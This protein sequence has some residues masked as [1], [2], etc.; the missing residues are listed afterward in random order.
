MILRAPM[1]RALLAAA[2][3]AHILTVAPAAVADPTEG[4]KRDALERLANSHDPA[5][6][7]TI[8]RLYVKQAGLKA[9]REL[10][11]ERGRAQGL[12]P[13]WD[14]HAPQ[15]RAAEL[16]LTELVDAAIHRDVDD[17]AWFRAAW[18]EESGKVLSA[19]EA[20]E[21]ATH[22]ASQ[23][24]RIQRGVIEMLIVGETLLANYTFTD[25]I[26]YDV[27]GSERELTELQELWWRNQ[28]FTVREV[29]HYP[30]TTRFA[31]TDPGVKYCKMLAIQGIDAVNRHLDAVVAQ[32]R[33]SLRGQAA[34]VDV[35]VR[36]HRSGRGV[37]G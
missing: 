33:S 35:Y 20:D 30:N 14:E 26:R 12:G 6:P 2:I 32:V 24:G 10:L 8:G 25:R 17:P 18:A 13:D 36:Q 3:A 27:R 23:G 11:A 37:N 19:E 15:W 4:L 7:L 22:F 28:P 5:I 21:I 29:T 1:K 31:G 34:R 16:E 9:V